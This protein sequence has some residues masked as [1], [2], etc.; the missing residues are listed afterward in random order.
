MLTFCIEDW[1]LK[2]E[3]E[4]LNIEYFWKRG[5]LGQKLP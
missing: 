2:I 5:I 4:K 3:D 1:I